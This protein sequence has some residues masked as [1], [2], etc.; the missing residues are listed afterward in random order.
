MPLR[1]RNELRG[2]LQDE[3]KRDLSLHLKANTLIFKEICVQEEYSNRL[4]FSIKMNVRLGRMDAVVY[5]SLLEHYPE[6]KEYLEKFSH[7]EIW[8]CCILI[9]KPIQI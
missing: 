4:C 3:M 1:F 2:K 9:Q 5:E 8:C 6:D 7:D